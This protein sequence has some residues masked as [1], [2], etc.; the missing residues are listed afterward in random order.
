MYDLIIIGGGPAGYAAALYAARAEIKT[1]V[2]EGNLPGGR[3]SLTDIIENYPGVKEKLSGYE[4][5]QIMKNQAIEAGAK[6]EFD[7]VDLFK[8][9]NNSF[10]LKTYSSEYSK[11]PAVLI[12]TGTN[13]K[14]LSVPGEKEFTGR[15]VSYCA[16]CDGPFFKDKKVAVIGGGDSA[17]KEALF[18]S[19][20]T[21]EVIVVHRRDKLR[22]EK[23]IQKKAFNT[24]NMSF[25]WDSV[26][27]EIIG[28]NSVEKIKLKNVKN[29]STKIIDLD[30]VFILIGSIPNNSLFTDLNITDE[31]GYILT[32]SNMK[33][34]IN[35]L[36]AAGDIRKKSLRQVATAVGDGAIAAVQIQEYLETL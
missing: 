12:A 31:T 9:E 25:Q 32:D 8:Y 36:Y 6:F 13:D 5:S 26:V 35:G 33:T 14:K 10:Y 4:L 3:I 16:T 22:A 23:V 21:N 2:I 30:G 7:N 15:G 18:L 1:L 28:D 19:K 17:I 29:K 27:E 11:I 20:I 24:Q 34:R